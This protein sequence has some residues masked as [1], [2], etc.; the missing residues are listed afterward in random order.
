[1]LPDRRVPAGPA[2]AEARLTDGVTL[3]GGHR[4]LHEQAAA[5]AGPFAVLAVRVTGLRAVN[6]RDGY[7]AGDALLAGA[8]RKLRRAAARAGATAYRD[9]GDRLVVLA[10]GMDETEAQRL[11]DDVAAEFGLGP[12]VALAVVVRRGEEDAEAVLA[13]ARRSLDATGAPVARKPM[14]LE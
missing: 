1:M 11:A 8:A 3:L 2:D 6:E 10:P 9:G 13:A 12:D 5:L 7:A 4:L 14:V